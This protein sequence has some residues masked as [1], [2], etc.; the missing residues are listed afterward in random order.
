ML[1]PFIVIVVYV[2]QN[3]L[4][5]TFLKNIV[6]FCVTQRVLNIPIL[7]Y[8]I[9][10]Y[11]ILYINLLN[12]VAIWLTCYRKPLSSVLSSKQT[13]VHTTS[14]GARIIL[15][16]LSHMTLAVTAPCSEF[17]RSQWPRGLRCGSAVDR[18]L[19]LRVRIPPG[20]W[21]SVSCECCMLSGR[22][23]CVRLITREG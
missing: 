11:I 18:L 3:C 21:M 6:S 2:Y 20:T 7:Y 12:C 9:L 14:F 22:G 17:C 19:R 16:L 10:Y 8:I 23:L 5:F 1:Y 15:Q 13:L 4:C